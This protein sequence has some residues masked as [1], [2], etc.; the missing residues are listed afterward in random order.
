MVVVHLLRRFRKDAAN[1][2][3]LLICGLR[4]AC[5]S[6]ISAILASINVLLAKGDAALTGKKT[7]VATHASFMGTPGT[8]HM[9]RVVD[10]TL[11]L[12]PVDL[13]PAQHAKRQVAQ[14]E[15]RSTQTDLHGIC[16]FVM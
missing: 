4:L 5:F 13:A 7:N 11:K 15:D 14:H 3:S 2:P 9:L 6:S 10:H 8:L 12:I 16:M 1:V